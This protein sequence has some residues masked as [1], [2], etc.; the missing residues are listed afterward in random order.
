[1]ERASDTG[2]MACLSDALDSFRCCLDN[3]IETFLRK[4]AVQYVERGWCAVYLFVDEA[5]FDLGRIKIEA[6]FTLSHKALI[7][8]TAS[9]TSMKDVSGFK[10]AQSLH[11][12]LIGQLGKRME[13]SDSGKIISAGITSREILD[14]AFEI[15]GASSAFIPCRC[16]LVECG[17]NEKVHQV[18][19]NYHFKFFQFDG[20]YYQFYKHI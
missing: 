15:I 18:Y 4:K 13:K 1:M 10:N 7:P 11:F 19:K 16:V 5:A 6:Y 9:K 3:D 17:D 20:E 12:V 8:M 2:S 14:V